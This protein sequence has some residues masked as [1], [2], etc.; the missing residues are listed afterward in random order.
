MSELQAALGLT[1]LPYMKTILDERKKVVDFYNDN[2]DFSN[3]QTLKIR[4]NTDWNYSY[5]P[6]IFENE[7]QLFAN[8]ER[9]K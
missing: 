7:R 8:S 6:I 9:F 1:V 3:I 5:Y 2:L 4:E